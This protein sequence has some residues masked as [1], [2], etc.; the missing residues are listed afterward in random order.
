MAWK[1]GLFLLFFSS[2]AK[3]GTATK[4]VIFGGVLGG[5]CCA[6]IQER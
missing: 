3:T 4:M 5:L 1:P 2:M 6:L